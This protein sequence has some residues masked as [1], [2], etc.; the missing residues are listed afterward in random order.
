MSRTTLAD[1][2][3]AAAAELAQ[4]AYYRR[5]MQRGLMARFIAVPAIRECC[6]MAKVMTTSAYI[7][8]QV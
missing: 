4:A 5:S 7:I 8:G 6:R 1:Y 3:A 2:R